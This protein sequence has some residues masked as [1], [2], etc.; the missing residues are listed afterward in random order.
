MAS[1][2]HGSNSNIPRNSILVHGVPVQNL[3]PMQGTHGL[4]RAQQMAPVHH[5]PHVQAPA[6]A[7][8]QFLTA[9]RASAP[10]S[11]YADLLAVIE[12]MG[13]DIRPTYAG[14]RMATERLKRGIVHAKSLVRECLAETERSARN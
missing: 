8:H 3:P 6:A 13:R 2:S 1:G 11:K 12:D 14:S 7:Q 5:Q 4:Q 10:Q 9:G